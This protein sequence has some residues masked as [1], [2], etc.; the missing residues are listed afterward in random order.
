MP[1]A[2]RQ[3]LQFVGVLISSSFFRFQALCTSYATATVAWLS[4]RDN[5]V[6]EGFVIILKNA[7]L[8]SFLFTDISVLLY[9]LYFLICSRC[10]RWSFGVVV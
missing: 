7:V 4:Q 10:L 5:R 9:C 1:C 2:N 8:L 3:E 6:C